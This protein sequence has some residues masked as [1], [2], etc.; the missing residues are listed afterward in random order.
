MA[1]DLSWRELAKSLWLALA[2]FNSPFN[3]VIFEWRCLNLREICFLSLCSR[4]WAT[5]TQIEVKGNL[6]LQ[7]SRNNS[8]VRQK[9]NVS[10]QRSRLV[11]HALSPEKALS[12]GAGSRLWWMPLVP[13]PAQPSFTKARWSF[14]QRRYPLHT[15]EES[16]EKI[17]SSRRHHRVY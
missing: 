3:E 7:I 2:N 8:F 10:V 16:S 14:A 5:K 12:L 11:L 15:F 4:S 1:A 17:P 13:P 9:R 6:I